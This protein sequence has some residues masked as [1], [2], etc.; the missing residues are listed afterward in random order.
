MPQN[1]N[2]IFASIGGMVLKNMHNRLKVIIPFLLLIPFALSQFFGLSRGLDN[3]VR[4]NLLTSAREPS[5]KVIIIGMDEASINDIGTWPWTR[6]YMADAINILT[7]AGAAVICANILYDLPS[8]EEYDE[9]LIDAARNTDR[10]VLGAMGEFAD[11]QYSTELSIENYIMPF[12]GLEDAVAVGFLNAEPD[13]DGVMRYA[14]TSLRYGDIKVYSLAYEAYSVYCSAMGIARGAIPL[15][16]SGQFPINYAVPS[17]G[18][19]ALSF[20][21]LINDELDPAMFKDKIVLIGPYA[22]GIESGNYAIPLGGRAQAYGVEINANIINNMLE[23]SFKRD[24]AWWVNLL[25]MTVIAAIAAV[26]MHRLKTL[27]A[28]VLTIGLIFAQLAVTMLLYLQFDV[29]LKSGDVILLLIFC[30]IANII[31]GILTAQYEKRHIQGIFGRFVSP[32]VVKELVTGSV[33]IQLGGSVKE[34]TVLFVDIR[35]FTAFSEANPPEKVV[36]M[37]NRYLGLTSRSIQENGGTIDKYI[38]D[39]TMAVFNAPNELPNHALCA[40]KAAWAMKLGSEPLREEILRDYGVDLQFGVG[41][42]TGQA[43]VGNMGSDFRMDYTAIGD[44]VNTAARLEANSGKGQILISD[45]TY[46]LV[47][48]DIECTD[49]G[50]LMVKNKKTGIQIY[51]LDNVLS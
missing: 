42:N 49:L 25:V 20:R 7:E 27:W 5:D 12:E 51:G 6:N 31:L 23:G 21:S 17:G 47:K 3:I 50:V 18:F 9:M 19:N 37:V 16:N 41:V 32:D 43:V 35:G 28:G 29:I 39:A 2:E 22:R 24:A 38:G 44:T 11:M 15:D 1:D 36:N 30:W 26:F 48:D 46:Q 33:D 13:R 45:A 8:I 14:L 40:V 4:D 10:L 34:I